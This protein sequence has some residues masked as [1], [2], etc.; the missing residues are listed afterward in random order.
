MESFS[1]MPAPQSGFTILDH[2]A[3]LGIE[4]FGKTLAEAFEQA[5][6]GL[7]SIILDLSRIKPKESRRILLR[8]SDSE[9]LLVRWLGEVLYLYDGEHFVSARFRVNELSLGRLTAEIYG[10]RFDARRHETRMD[11]KA[12]TYHQ[13][14]VH[15]DEERSWVRV[16]LDV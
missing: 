10:E 15:Q 16:F 6:V 2:P 7:M 3:D 4:A 12:V 9:S 11:V 13:L 14:E 1:E 8:S 5:A